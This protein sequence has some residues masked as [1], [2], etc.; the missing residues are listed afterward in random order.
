MT[1]FSKTHIA[2]IRG[3]KVYE[4]PRNFYLRVPNAPVKGSLLRSIVP[5][6]YDTYRVVAKKAA[7]TTESL[8]PPCVTIIYIARKE[9]ERKE[10]VFAPTRRPEE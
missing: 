1:F 7:L 3:F 8:I 10:P 6:R 9:Q 2:I 5:C 4:A